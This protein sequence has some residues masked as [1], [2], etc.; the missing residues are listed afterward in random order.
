MR[1]YLKNS[2]KI[3]RKKG[4]GGGSKI[5]VHRDCKNLYRFGAGKRGR[6]KF[7]N[8]RSVC[9]SYPCPCHPYCKYKFFKRLSNSEYFRYMINSS[10]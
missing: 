6:K 3:G 9:S 5:S 10:K 2:K 4:R 7:G 8:S 1:G